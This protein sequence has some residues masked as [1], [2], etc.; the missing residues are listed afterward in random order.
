[1][2][3]L[4]NKSH[5]CSFA[6]QSWE[7]W[8]R[9]QQCSA[10]VCAPAA[11]ELRCSAAA[12]T[13]GS[14]SLP[15][16]PTVTWNEKT[17]P[18]TAASPAPLPSLTQGKLRNETGRQTARGNN[19]KRHGGVRLC[20]SAAG[21]EHLSCSRTPGA[22]SSALGRQR[23]ALLWADGA[24]RARR[25]ELSGRCSCGPSFGWM[26]WCEPKCAETAARRST[27]RNRGLR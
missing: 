10:A 14:Q 5:S 17:P 3:L 8:R 9:A 19:R 18:G 25:W 16:A 26:R 11:P 1:M 27:L 13:R 22:R 6:G 12:P 4:I 23:P 21:N 15:V 20:G 2:F 24:L 7:G